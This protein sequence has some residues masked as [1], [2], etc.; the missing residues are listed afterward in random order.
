MPSSGR[1]SLQA[2]LSEPFFLL[3]ESLSSNLIPEVFEITG[4][5]IATIN[6]EWPGRDRRNSPIP[7]E[8]IFPHLAARAGPRAV[9]I[10]ADRRAFRKH[11]EAIDKHNIS[12]LWLR[13]L[14]RSP[15]YT[16]QLDMICTVIET[17]H[18][19]IGQS[20]VP[21]YLRV[22]LDPNNSNRPFLERLQ[23]TVLRK[24]A[25]WQRVPLE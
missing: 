13:A 2:P 22:R 7:D 25:V 11:R 16:E 4:Q 15:K 23:G 1:S 19:L 10:T 6:D 8:E 9:W 17:V 5:S 12:I 3:D 24:P 18:L 20:D 21:N 14:G